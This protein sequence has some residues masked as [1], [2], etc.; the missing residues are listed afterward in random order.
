MVLGAYFEGKQK[1]NLASLSAYKDGM[2][3][4]TFEKNANIKAI[5]WSDMFCID[6]CSD[7]VFADVMWKF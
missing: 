5:W 3:A 6:I 4:K 2:T 7:T 1:A